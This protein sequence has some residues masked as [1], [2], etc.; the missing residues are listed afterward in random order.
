[1][2]KEDVVRIHKG[3]LLNHEMNEISPFAATR[4][5]LDMIIRTDRSHTEEDMSYDIT[6]RWNLKIDTNELTCNTETES[7]T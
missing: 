5:D 7:Q 4:R 1:M 2:C 3:R 6:Y